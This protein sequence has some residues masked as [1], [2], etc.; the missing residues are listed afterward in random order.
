LPKKK[1]ISHLNIRIEFM[2]NW[3]APENLIQWIRRLLVPRAF[4]LLLAF[5]ALVV[6]ELR[7][8][9]IEIAVGSY[10]TTTNAYRPET[11]NIWD[12]GRQNDSARQ[13]LSQFMNQRQSAQLEARRATSLAQVVSGID[14]ERGAMIS[15][16]HFVDLYLALP[17]VIS[18]EIISPYT[19]LAQLSSGQWQRTFFEQP[20]HQLSIYLLDSQNQV[21]HRLI[22]GS[23][24]L[25]HVLR[26]EVAVS[27]SL[28]GLSD[29][30]DH[31]YP[32]QRFFELLNNYPAGV[33]QGIIANPQDLLR[34]SG[35]IVRVGISNT[36]F[37][38]VIDLGFEVEGGQ[39]LKVILTQGNADDIR[40]LQRAL[41]G[42]RTLGRPIFEKESP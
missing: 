13:A 26:G 24:L 31:I 5:A 11:G 33:R 37:G 32:A 12:Q 21:L 18:H 10:L 4:G 23:G 39:G 2:I 8:D 29:F 25:E 7:F 15:A 14:D 1:G 27:S 28:S 19:L 3:Y 20:E 35:R 34:I 6:T 42:S 9:W 16:E 41:D 38:D 40:R 22:V 17:P 36:T 30:A